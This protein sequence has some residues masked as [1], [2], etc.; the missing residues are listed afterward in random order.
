MIFLI[1]A[2]IFAL[3]QPACVSDHDS[4]GEN[5]HEDVKSTAQPLDSKRSRVLWEAARAMVGPS[6]ASTF[7]SNWPTATTL[8]TYPYTSEDP[9]A[10]NLLLG[11][12][13]YANGNTLGWFVSCMRKKAEG[14]LY[15]CQLP[16]YGSFEM[17]SFTCQGS[18]P[19]GSKE[20]RGGQCKGFANLVA[21]RSGI[22]QGA[23]YAFK[24]FPSDATINSWSTAA[25]QMPYASPTN[26]LPGDIL[27]QPYGHAAIVARVVSSTQ[28][29]IF[30]S[31]WVA[32]GDGDEVVG[33]HTLGFTGSGWY[34]L[35]NYRVL[36]CAYTGGC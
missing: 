17:P 3:V 18:C 15:S 21:Y 20:F 36:K 30:D 16:S 28:V 4:T 1:C 11:S 23:N 33:S 22:Y 8:A 13:R 32:G 9:G 25:D 27:R 35:G 6:Q 19:S 10:W 5:S 12:P 26:L 7:M 14:P 34:N 29:V 24:A 2:T 31:N